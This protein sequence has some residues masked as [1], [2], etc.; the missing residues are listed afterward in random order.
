MSL[1]HVDGRVQEISEAAA[2]AAA[3][4]RRGRDRELGTVAPAVGERDW[5]GEGKESMVHVLTSFLLSRLLL[6]S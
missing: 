4:E 6:T 3:A 1:P 2:D 5:G